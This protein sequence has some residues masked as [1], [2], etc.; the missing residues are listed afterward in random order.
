MCVMLPGGLHLYL[1]KYRNIKFHE[2][3]FLQNHGL[4]HVYVVYAKD[5]YAINFGEDEN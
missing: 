1:I 3:S 2:I 5:N 4:F